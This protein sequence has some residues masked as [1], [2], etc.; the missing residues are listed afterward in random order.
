MNT[1]ENE[2][3]PV[4]CRTAMVLGVSAF[5]LLLQ[6]NSGKKKEGGKRRTKKSTTQKKHDTI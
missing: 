3:K 4:T 2:T 6:I 5:R 1:D